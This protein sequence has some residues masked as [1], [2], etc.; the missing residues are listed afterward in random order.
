MTIALPTLRQV[1][2]PNYSSRG[3]ARISK[4]IAHTCQGN[5]DGAAAWFAQRASQVSAHLIL[6]ESGL[7]AYQCVA[8]NDKAWHACNFNPTTIGVE[9]GGWAEKGYPAAELNADANIIA[10]LLHR[11]GLPLRWAEHG[12]G[13]GFCSHWDLGAAGGNHDDITTDPAVWQAFAARVRAAYTAF[14]PATLPDW[15]LHGLP[16]PLS[17]VTPP[18]APARWTPPAHTLK[19]PGVLVEAPIVGS[20]VWV[21]EK[22]VQLGVNSMLTVDGLN[23]PQ[24]EAAIATFQRTRGL[25]IDGI[26][27]RQTIAALLAA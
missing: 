25:Y 4:V 7:Y 9:M 5:A 22:L 20:M 18:S 15:A 10:W 12:L 26:A 3:G 24:T 1:P 14:D 11:Y 21:Q 16:A 13:D 2:S 17:I 19:E 6:H 23:G 8:L 27:G